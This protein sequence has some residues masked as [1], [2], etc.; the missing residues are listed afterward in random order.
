MCASDTFETRISRGKFA[1]MSA[2]PKT[3]IHLVSHSRPKTGRIPTSHQRSDERH[4]VGV[5]RTPRHVVSSGSCVIKP[6]AVSEDYICPSL[7]DMKLARGCHLGMPSCLRSRGTGEY[8]VTG[9]HFLVRVLGPFPLI[10]YMSDYFAPSGSSRDSKARGSLCVWGGGGYFLS[11]PTRHPAHAHDTGAGL[12]GRRS[13]PREN[14]AGF[15]L[16]IMWC[17]MPRFG[18]APGGDFRPKFRPV[19]SAE[20][21]G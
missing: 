13:N 16:C 4:L 5:I 2:Y 6:P 12:Q 17:E 10:R 19:V 21:R 8:R 20:W 3:R 7:P 1:R 18:I 15:E 9:T 11:A 14:L